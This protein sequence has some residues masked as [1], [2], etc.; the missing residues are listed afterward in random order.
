MNKDREKLILEILLQ[1]KEV[2]VKDL[3]ARL[4]ASEP[5][6]RR[7]LNS[8]QKQNLIRRVHGG[9]V[10]EETGVS[11]T[12]IPYLIRELE[13]S[14]EKNIIAKYAA[15]LVKDGDTI[16]LDASSSA[17]RIIPY[18]T[19]RKQITVITS[20]IQALNLLS[21]YEINA[22]CTGGISINSCL[23]LVGNDAHRT[24]HTYHADI[25]FISCRGISAEGE[26]SDISIEEN[27]VRREMIKRSKKSY[28]L[29]VK[30][31]F[32]T[33]YFHKLC[34]ASELSGIIA[35]EELPEALQ[36]YKVYGTITRKAEAVPARADV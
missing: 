5:S 35:S 32:N 22:I 12:K 13:H 8:L 26:L 7:D 16:F 23:S 24:I 31:K 21:E 27:L 17:C 10:L 1:E 36:K 33:T 29:C 3:A 34:D 4:Y 9:A 11:K 28:L 2:N 18:L 30:E 20:G 25:C 6:I 15:D 19:E 14:S